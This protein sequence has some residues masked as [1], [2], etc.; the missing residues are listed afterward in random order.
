[1]RW[2]L[3]LLSLSLAGCVKGEYA[4]RTI[5]EPIDLQ[6]LRQL[7]V[8]KDDLGSCLAVLGA[9]LDVREYG[10]AADGT[11]GMALVW[12]WRRNVGWGLQMSA[13]ITRDASVSFEFDW[14]GTYLPGCVLWF[15]QDLKLTNYREGKV[16]ELLAKRRRPSASVP[17]Q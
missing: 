5:N 15:D 14:E 6:R 16:G 11:S 2:S 3:G 9:P 1:M 8:G 7:E 12:F 10:V 13:A 4:Q 17:S